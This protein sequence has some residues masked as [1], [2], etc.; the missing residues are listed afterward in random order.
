[1]VVPSAGALTAP[2]AP[3]ALVVVGAALSGAV[4]AAGLGVGL[5]VVGAPADEAPLAGCVDAGV[6]AGAD[7]GSAAA[8]A[9]TVDA[10]GVL[11]VLEGA[12]EFGCVPSEVCA[13][14]DGLLVPEFTHPKP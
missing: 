5:A 13:A 12:V 11:V 6:D 1:V 10:A 8:G 9:S 3:G 4:L 7:A 14:P 2:V